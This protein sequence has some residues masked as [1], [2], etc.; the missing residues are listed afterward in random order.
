M[1]TRLFSWIRRRFT[2]GN[3][4]AIDGF[5]DNPYLIL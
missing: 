1:I 2:K 5:K 4:T 3:K